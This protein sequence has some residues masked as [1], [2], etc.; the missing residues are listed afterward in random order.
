M[1]I[2]KCL[3]SIYKYLAY[4]QP[5]AALGNTVCKSVQMVCL[6]SSSDQM[7]IQSNSEPQSQTGKDVNSHLKNLINNSGKNAFL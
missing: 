1:V 3:L 4:P 2:K 7:T 6:K 5:G